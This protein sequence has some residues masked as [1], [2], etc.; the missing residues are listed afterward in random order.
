MSSEGVCQE[1]AILTS[2]LIIISDATVANASNDSQAQPSPP[3]VDAEA[4]AGGVIGGMIGLGIAGSGIFF[5]RRRRSQQAY[6]ICPL[7]H[8]NGA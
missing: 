8:Q 2:N 5:W 1:N 4:I 3:K 7:V 6:V